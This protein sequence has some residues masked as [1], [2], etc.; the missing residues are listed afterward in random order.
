MLFRSALF[1]PMGEWLSAAL[2]LCVSV[3]GIFV[4]ARVAHAFHAVATYAIILGIFVLFGGVLL[5]IGLFSAFATASCLYAFLLL[6]RR[7]PFVWGL[8]LIPLI[9]ALLLFSS[10]SAILLS[11]STLPCALLLAYS[12]KNKLGRVS[13]VCH[14]S[15]GICL[16]T[17]A[18]FV[19]AVWET[20]GEISVTAAKDFIDAVIL[21]HHQLTAGL[22]NLFKCIFQFHGYS[23]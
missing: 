14:I 12:I 17:I 10:N 3:L 19:C 8:P 6:K 23:K 5:P 13:A 18:L 20:A 1:L 9:I 11:L 4:L 16:F 22:L 21:Q 7:N 2:A 15:F